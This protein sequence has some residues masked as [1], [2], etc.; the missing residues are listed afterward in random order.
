M[1]SETADFCEEFAAGGL[2]TLTALWQL[3]KGFSSL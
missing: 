3:A 2:P 1:T